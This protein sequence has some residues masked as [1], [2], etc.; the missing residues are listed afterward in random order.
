VIPLVVALAFVLARGRIPLRGLALLLTAASLWTSAVG[1]RGELA[2]EPRYHGPLPAEEQLAAWIEEQEQPLVFATT[3]PWSLGA[4]T[5]G[6][7][8]HLSCRARPNQLPTYFDRLKVDYL[9]LPDLDRD[10]RFLKTDAFDL[11]PIRRFQGGQTIGV[12]GIRRH[13]EP[14]EAAP[15]L[16]Q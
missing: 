3:R 13:A 2:R 15:R 10:C 6:L 14:A 8:H 11:R 1:I 5:R 16:P 7:F 12:Y 4:L 9:I